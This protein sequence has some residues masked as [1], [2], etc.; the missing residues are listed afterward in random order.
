MKK[1]TSL[2]LMGAALAACTSPAPKG[3]E[4][5]GT[6][7]DS[8]MNNKSL[9][10]MEGDS[11]IDSTVVAGKTF[12]FKGDL[13]TAVVYRIAGK[14]MMR[15]Q[16]RYNTL[17]RVL[18]DKGTKLD[19]QVTDKVTLNDNGGSNQILS[20][21]MDNFT[22]A[23]QEATATYQSMLGANA[24][25]DSIKA[26]AE[27]ANQQLN[28]LWKDAVAKNSDNVAGAAIFADFCRMLEPEEFDSIYQNLKYADL[29]E[30]VKTQKDLF[31]NVKNT[32]EGKMFVDFAGKDMEGNAVKLSD[33]V[34]KGKYVLVDFWASWCGPCRHEIPNLIKVNKQFKGKNFMV[35]GV[36][37]WDQMDDFKAAVDEL[38]V[39]YTQMFA[40]ESR[41]ATTLYGIQGIPHI[42]L[43]APD[44]TI[45]KRGLRGE[46]I[47]ETVKE[48]LK[49]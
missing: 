15:G 28:K 41:E 12:A 1:I 26:F 13:D 5:S 27:E 31:D 10:L 3:Y 49:K 25:Q 34:G 48:Y 30:M 46:A 18:L 36:D 19:V 29:F 43:F 9:Y 21:F 8:V 40:S 22:K 39:N 11:V 23:N 37:V 24:S 2:F 16:V 17:T 44:G 20:D 35:L 32:S 4:I 33:Y 45:L 6:Y 47:A 38:K 42:I 14:S 7:A